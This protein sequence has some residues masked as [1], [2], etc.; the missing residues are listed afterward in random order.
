MDYRPLVIE[1]AKKNGIDPELVQAIATVES[2]WSPLAIKFEPVYRYLFF[3]REWASNHHIDLNTETALQSFSYGLL[4][5]MGANC[6]EYGFKGPLQKL[7]LPESIELVL[8]YGC[9]HL[10][11]LMVRCQ[12]ESDVISSYNQGSPRKTPG[13]LYE[14]QKYVD[15]VYKE[16]LVL[17]KLS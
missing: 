16:L 10:K 12:T 1:T 3:P 8:N 11:K 9:I 5:I 14:N 4:Q 13:G 15:K 6:R 17:R 2:S 7:F